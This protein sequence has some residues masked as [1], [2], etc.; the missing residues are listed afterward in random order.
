[1]WVGWVV[2]EDGKAHAGAAAPPPALSPCRATHYKCRQ[3]GQPQG[4]GRGEG[5]AGW[6]SR[7]QCESC[8]TACL[9]GISRRSGPCPRCVASG[10]S[11]GPCEKRGQGRRHAM[12]GRRRRGKGRGRQGSPAYENTHVCRCMCVHARAQ[13]PACLRSHIVPLLPAPNAGQTGAGA[14]CDR[15]RA[16]AAVLMPYSCASMHTRPSPA[17]MRAR[18]PARTCC[19]LG[20]RVVD[21]SVLQVA[22][23]PLHGRLNARVGHGHGG[24]PAVQQYRYSIGTAVQVRSRRGQGTVEVWSMCVA[25][26]QCGAPHRV[27][28]GRE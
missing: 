2:Q 10:R 28:R 25:L 8:S 17:C 7:P 21:V 20:Q 26:L 12:T 13:M 11:G 6:C 18:T 4:G 1:M 14:G 19:W 22:Q 16:P 27:C 23:Q 24:A 15:L 9:L 3:H 5:G